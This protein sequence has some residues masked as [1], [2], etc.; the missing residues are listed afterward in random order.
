[1]FP[2]TDWGRRVTA[3]LTGH[4]VL[5]TAVEPWYGHFPG[6]GEIWVASDGSTRVKPEVT[7]ASVN[8]SLEQRRRALSSGWADPLSW[9]RRGFWLLAGVAASP[10]PHL[11]CLVLEASAGRAERVLARLSERGWQFLAD[12]PTPARIEGEA[13]VAHPRG[14]P[15]LTRAQRSQT[16]EPA[17]GD[18]DAVLV[19]R[20]QHSA[21]CVVRGVCSLVR[22]A[23][24][25]ERQEPVTGRNKVMKA[26]G[27]RLGGVFASQDPSAHPGAAMS[28][29]WLATAVRLSRLPMTS[30]PLRHEAA[31]GW[32]AEADL[33]EAWWTTVVDR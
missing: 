12:H 29:E 23:V 27:L 9:H 20:R 5:D 21:P 28:P 6:L 15:F 14:T 17:R 1:M 19:E 30:V 25:V 4:P 11:G 16:A 32:D 8:D 2:K 13:L 26:A 24:G 22:V 7:P 31:D 18:T 33:I 10:A 3:P